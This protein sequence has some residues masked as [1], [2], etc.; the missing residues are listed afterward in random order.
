MIT[1]SFPGW[2]GVHAVGVGTGIITGIIQAGLGVYC[3]K[4]R[5]VW[6]RTKGAERAT[7]WEKVAAF[8]FRTN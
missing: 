8:G 1:S 6:C 5:R 2:A 3:H 4:F 7:V